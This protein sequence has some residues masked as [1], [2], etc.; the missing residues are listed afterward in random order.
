MELKREIECADAE[1][2]RYTV[3][4]WQKVITT[5][6]LS[7]ASQ[8]LPGSKSFKT[9]CGLHV[10]YIDEDTFEIFDTHTRIFRL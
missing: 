6:P 9:A 5:K 8:R 10:E 2:R 4:E 3:Q 7:G 1:G